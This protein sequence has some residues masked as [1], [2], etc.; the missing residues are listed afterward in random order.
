MT[1]FIGSRRQ[2]TTSTAGEGETWPLVFKIL[3]ITSLPTRTS[4]TAA[5]VCVC[6]WELVLNK[7]EDSEK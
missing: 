5:D 1:Q 4:P 7:T 2:Q 6:V 3:D